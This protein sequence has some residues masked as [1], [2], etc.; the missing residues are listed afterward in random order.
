MLRKLRI[1]TAG[2]SHG[3]GLIGIIEGIP[4]RLELTESQINYD[5]KRRQGGYGRGSRMKIEEDEIEIL[6]GVR[7]GLTLGTP[8]SLLLIN[9]DWTN[10]QKGMSSKIEDKDSITPV[11]RPR[12]G[13][14]DLAGIIKYGHKDARNVLE[15]S[16]ARET[17]IKVALG[18]IAK[19][20]LSTFNIKIFSLVLSIGGIS[21]D[22]DFLYSGYTDFNHISEMAEKSIL[23]CPNESLTNKFKELIDLASSEGDTLGG[24]FAVI[25]EGLPVGLGNFINWDLRLDARLSY[26]MM[27]IQAIKAVEIGKGIKLAHSKGSEVM[28]EIYYQKDKLFYRKT[29]NAGGVEGGMTNGMPLVIKCAMKPIPT[30]KKPLTSVDIKTKETV[31]AVYER[32]DVCAVPSASVIAE[33]MSALV[34]ADAFLEKFSGDSINETMN[35]YN[36]YLRAIVSDIE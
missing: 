31:K 33:A 35:N 21:L 34:I 3:K 7:W 16:S 5:L 27:G 15:R 17:A 18:A 29:N 12:P 13:H 32:S 24:T 28:D 14:A 6:S 4:A 19:T 23:R 30:L 1:L 8:I 36:S 26:A 25:V 2:E 20:L 11:T 9:K 22:D 10:W